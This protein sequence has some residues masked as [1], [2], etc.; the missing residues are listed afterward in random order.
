VST[1]QVY[2]HV[3]VE[4][5]REVFLMSH[6]RARRP[7]GARSTQ[8]GE[9]GRVVGGLQADESSDAAGFAAAEGARSVR[10]PGAR[11][12]AAARLAQPPGGD[13]TSGSKGGAE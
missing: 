8:A 13:E 5:L 7:P 6:P 11:S 10:P 3:T 1:T 4:H 12:A 9:D 2:T